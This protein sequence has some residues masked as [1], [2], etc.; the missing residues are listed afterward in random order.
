MQTAPINTGLPSSTVISAI[1]G[2][3]HATL[4][5]YTTG[6][7]MLKNTFITQEDSLVKGPLHINSSFV[8]TT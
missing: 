1:L 6:L 3:Q 4:K 5:N 2:T 7:G 8:F